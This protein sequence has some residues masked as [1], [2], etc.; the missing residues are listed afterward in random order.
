MAMCDAR[1]EK[2]TVPQNVAR[3]PDAAGV[4]RATIC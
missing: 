3:I 4:L 1:E 2:L